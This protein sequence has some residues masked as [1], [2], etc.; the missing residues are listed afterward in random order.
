MHDCGEKLL[1]GKAIRAEI[2]KIDADGCKINSV[3]DGDSDGV[4]D[5]SDLC[6]N[7]P[8]NEPV[9]IDG[10]ALSELD[11]DG[12][13][14]NDNV[15]QCPNTQNGA[16]VSWNGC[17]VAVQENEDSSTED[18]SS[19]IPGFAAVTALLSILF[20]ISIRKDDTE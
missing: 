16:T 14:V 5:S 7:T 1:Q 15:D 9:N 11:S 10:R 8:I 20:A 17:K 4:E 3:Q 19:S 6:N 2:R 18:D 13:G 12:D